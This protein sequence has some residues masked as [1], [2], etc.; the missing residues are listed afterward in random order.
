MDLWAPV[1]GG[2]EAVGRRCYTLLIWITSAVSE[3]VI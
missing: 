1:S 2:F 3:R